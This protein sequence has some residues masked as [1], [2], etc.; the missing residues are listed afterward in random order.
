MIAWKSQPPWPIPRGKPT[1]W[2][3]AGRSPTQPREPLCR[4]WVGVVVARVA[5]VMV[6]ASAYATQASA[7]SSGSPDKPW[8]PARP[9]PVGR[10]ASWDRPRGPPFD[11]GARS[12][13]SPP[14]LVAL[15]SSHFVCSWV[16]TVTLCSTS[17]FTAKNG[18]CIAPHA[19]RTQTRRASSDGRGAAPGERGG[20]FGTRPALGHG[21]SLEFKMKRAKDM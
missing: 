18:S 5:A 20:T 15:S 3:R 9:R 8:A 10:L 11:V 7:A 16:T 14:C 19:A 4:L 13:S 17:S 1:D 21:P 12:N 6:V 2:P